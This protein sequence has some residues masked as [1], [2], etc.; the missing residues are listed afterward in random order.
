[1][2]T[3]TPRNDL[4]NPFWAEDAEIGNGE[5]KLINKTEADFWKKFVLKYLTPLDKSEEH[6][7]MV[8]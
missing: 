8:G 4:E 1:M 3:R 7:D 2:T 5:L 6:Q